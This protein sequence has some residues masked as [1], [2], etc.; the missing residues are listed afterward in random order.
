LA[1]GDGDRHPAAELVGPR[2]VG[3]VDVIA[4]DVEIV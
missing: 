3:E 2:V 4:G 1:D